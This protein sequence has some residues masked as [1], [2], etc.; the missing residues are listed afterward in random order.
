MFLGEIG[1]TKAT[2]HPKLIFQNN[3]YVLVNNR[4]GKTTWYCRMKNIRQVYCKARL[5]LSGKTLTVIN[6]Q[7]NHDPVV[8]DTSDLFKTV[9]NIVRS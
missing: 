7:H 8:K 1:F 4:P 9:V 6:G 2:K 3:E 5:S